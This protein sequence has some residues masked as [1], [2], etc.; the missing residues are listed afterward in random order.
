MVRLDTLR[1]V[2]VETADGTALVVQDL[3]IDDS[4]WSLS[5]LDLLLPADR[6]ARGGA[7]AKPLRCLLPPRGIDWLNTDAGK[8][9]LTVWMQEL[10][11]APTQPLPVAGG[12]AVRVRVLEPAR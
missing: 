7:E 9:H 11:D 2:Q 6:D 8:L 1:G 5:Y 10:R 3:L 4:D 12:E